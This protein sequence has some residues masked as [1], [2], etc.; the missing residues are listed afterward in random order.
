[1]IDEGTDGEAAKRRL[2]V[3]IR[4]APDRGTHGVIRWTR[5]DLHER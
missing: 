1:M 5:D 2:L 3:R 4:N